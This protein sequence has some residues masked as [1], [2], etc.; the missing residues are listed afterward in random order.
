MFQ[1]RKGHATAQLARAEFG[2]QFRAS[3]IDPEFRVEDS[4][5]ARLEDRM[6]GLL[7]PFLRAKRVTLRAL[8]HRLRHVTMLK[9]VSRSCNFCRG[10][11]GYGGSKCILAAV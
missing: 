11:Q 2:V 9:S 3:F 1:I 7:T 8:A 10:R 6:A 4:S 5:I